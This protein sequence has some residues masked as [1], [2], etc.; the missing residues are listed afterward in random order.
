M[1]FSPQVDLVAGV[2]I[3][4]IGVDAVRHVERRAQL[5]LA[6]LPVVFGVHQLIESVVWW[7]LAGDVDDGVWHAARWVYLSIAFGLVPVWVP[8][9]VGALERGSVARRT[10]WLMAL[11]AAVAVMLMIGVI[12]GPISSTVRGHHID[13]EVDLWHGGLLVLLY[14]VATCGSLLLSDD[15]HVRRF[16]IVNLGAV[17]VLV[18]VDQRAFISLWCAWAAVTSLAIAL[19]LR[20][21]HS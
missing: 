1:C 6:L 13:Y 18:V 20:A 21:G 7:G 5:P 9:A 2:V 16:G 12:R 10:R 14:V 17:V 19:H 3:A 4:G 15:V 8:V 11:G